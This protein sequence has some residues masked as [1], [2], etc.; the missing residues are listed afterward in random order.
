[1]KKRFSFLCGRVFVGLTPVI[2]I[3]ERSDYFSAN[4]A[5]PLGFLLVVS[6]IF[7]APHPIKKGKALPNGAFFQTYLVSNPT[8]FVHFNRGVFK[9][10]SS[11]VFPRTRLISRIINFGPTFFRYSIRPGSELWYQ[12]HKK[13]RISESIFEV[14]THDQSNLRPCLFEEREKN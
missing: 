10:G 9:N 7:T 3:S 6:S 1:M 11:K 2:V 12:C 8:H 4:E 14:G 5:I 13:S